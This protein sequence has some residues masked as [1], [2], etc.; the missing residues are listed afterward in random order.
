MTQTSRAR[1]KEKEHSEPRKTQGSDYEFEI[2]FV[3]L[4][5]AQRESYFEAM[6]LLNEMIL[7]AVELS[8]VNNGDGSPLLNQP[9]DARQQA[10]DET[11]LI[12]QMMT[13][14]LAVFSFMCAWAGG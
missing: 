2:R 12:T 13:P 11:F 7:Q 6:R 4:P 9:S 14:L 1:N 5:P 8:Q 3:P 10:T